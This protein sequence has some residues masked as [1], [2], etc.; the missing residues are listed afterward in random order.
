MKYSIIMPYY[1]RP[2]LRFTL[3]SYA[4]LYKDRKD[5]EIII[6]EDSK[7]RSSEPFHKKMMKIIDKYSKDLVIRVILD[8]KESFNPSSK[9]NIGAKESKGK[10][11]ML[12]NPEV[13]HTLDIF[14]EID[15]ENLNNVYIICSCKAVYLSEDKG[16]FKD[17]SYRFYM[18]YQHTKSRDVRYHFCTLITKED[19][20]KVGGFNEAFCAGIA[21]DDDNF[22]KRVQKAKLIMLPRDDLVTIHIEHSRS[23]QIS[24]EDY[25]RLTV[26]N[27]NIWVSQ[28]ASGNF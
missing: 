14:K 4:G 3:D 13:P 8:H 16:T 9:Y 26:I 22:V 5:V 12:T 21:Y 2:E 6:V 25:H 11:L 19:Y 18:W 20:T 28:L 10:V 1:N 7:N 24:A 27:R 15:K 23:Y 17:S